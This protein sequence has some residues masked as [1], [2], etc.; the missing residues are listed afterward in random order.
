MLRTCFIT[1]PCTCIRQNLFYYIPMYMYLTNPFLL[2]SPVHSRQNLFYY[3]PLFSYKTCFI[4]LHC[5]CIRHSPVYVFGKTC[6]ITFPCTKLFFALRCPCIWKR[7]IKHFPSMYL[8][9]LVLLHSPVHVL[10]KTHFI[11]LRCTFIWHSPSMYLTKLVFIA[12]PCSFIRQ[13]FT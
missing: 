9:E 11:A 1:F 2:H 8:T 3:I 10:D 7:C 4:A 5:P 6:F 13:S 12:F